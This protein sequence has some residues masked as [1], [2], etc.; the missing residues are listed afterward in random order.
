MKLKTEFL[1]GHKICK[2][3]LENMYD[4]ITENI[5]ERNKNQ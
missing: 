5:K 4:N 2:K 3:K 1:E